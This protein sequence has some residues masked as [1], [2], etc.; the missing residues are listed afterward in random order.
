MGNLMRIAREGWLLILL[1]LAF[2]CGLCAA[3]WAIPAESPCEGSYNNCTLPN[4]E[5]TR[6]HFICSQAQGPPNCVCCMY[7]VT[8][9]DCDGNRTTDCVNVVLVNSNMG[10]YQCNPSSS[11]CLLQTCE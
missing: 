9:Y 5:V 4:C 10:D 2:T 6:I 1:M 11:T 7:E 8:D 3:C